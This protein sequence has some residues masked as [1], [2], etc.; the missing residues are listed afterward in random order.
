ML[1][2]YVLSWEMGGRFY[3]SQAVCF[4]INK[5]N[6]IQKPGSYSACI[7]TQGLPD[8]AAQPPLCPP[9]PDFMSPVRAGLPFAFLF[10]P[11]GPP[12]K[13]ELWLAFPPHHLISL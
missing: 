2:S 11:K 10:P 13:S 9:G 7:L 6:I 8:S 5:Q 12:A 4:L 1:I 3:F